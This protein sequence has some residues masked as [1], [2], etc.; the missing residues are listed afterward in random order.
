MLDCVRSM[1]GYGM[2]R[3]EK[4][5]MHRWSAWSKSARLFLETI[6]PYL[7]SNKRREQAIKALSADQSFSG[8]FPLTPST[9]IGED[10][11]WLT[12][13]YEAEGW[14]SFRPTYGRK[15][16]I[17]GA[18][19]LTITQKDREILDEVSRIVGSGSIHAFRSGQHHCHKWACGSATARMVLSTML[20][21]LRSP[22]R[23]KQAT[24][25]LAL[26][27]SARQAGA[28]AQEQHLKTLVH[29]RDAITGRIISSH[30]PLRAAGWPGVK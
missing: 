20:P 11:F 6:Y 26:D 7:R 29:V 22:K 21:H 23:I 3:K 5:G 13:L 9:P 2:V 30:L 16:S 8:V 18:L 28:I 27:S 24:T 17:H 4:S 10:W 12:G 25:A 15:N 14:T 19:A 1:V